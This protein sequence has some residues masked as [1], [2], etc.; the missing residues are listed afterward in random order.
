MKRAYAVQQLDTFLQRN[1]TADAILAFVVWELGMAPPVVDEETCQALMHIYISPNRR[2]WDE[3]IEKD[4][5]V[6]LCKARRA[7]AREQRAL[8][9]KQLT[10]GL[11]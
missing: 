7:K 3:E 11:K 8:K 4:A 1:P 6:V 10:G 5:K 2:Q 9:R